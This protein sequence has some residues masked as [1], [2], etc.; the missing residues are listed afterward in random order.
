MIL[1]LGLIS[2]YMISTSSAFSV[3]LKNE[4][5]RGF[6]R[7]KF[8]PSFCAKQP[9]RSSKNE[10]EFSERPYL[11]WDHYE[12]SEKPK[13]DSRFLSKAHGVA[14]SVE[15]EAAKDKIFANKLRSAQDVFKHL[16]PDLV[17]KSNLV[18]E[19]F[20]NED[21]LAKVQHVL[22]Q[23]TKR[24]KFLFENPSNPSNVWA[25][26]RTIDSFGIQYVDC[27]MNSGMYAGKQALNQKRGM[28]TAMGSAQWL[29]LKNHM[30]TI[31]AVNEIRKQGYKIYASD[32]NPASKDV[33]D[34]DWDTAP[35]CVV[36]GNEDRGISQQMRECA[37][38]T[39]I[40]PMCGFAE[41][42]NLSV[43]T[44]ITLAYMNA[45]SIGGKGPLRKGDLDDY[46]YD[47]LYLKGLLNS[48]SKKRAGIL[49][50]KQNGIV[51]PEEALRL[52]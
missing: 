3:I 40:L 30:S 18:L 5:K 29:S 32:L 28:R 46:E 2:S 50:L 21:R 12:F 52:I 8:H 4:S 51:I 25:C 44:S 13:V 7:S 6:L 17:K 37:D 34:L 39:F 14:L 24:S 47:C 43:A 10:A 45:K 33:R 22:K 42:F 19:S 27:I 9:S 35:I 48:L 26:L 31:E 20:I 23:R 49:L 11:G 36:M 15:E 1:K 41:S 38:E 16:D